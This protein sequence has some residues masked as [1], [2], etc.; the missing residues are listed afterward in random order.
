MKVQVD[1]AEA[2]ATLRPGAATAELSSDDCVTLLV[3][4]EDRTLALK[5]APLAV[6]VSAASVR[7][8]AQRIILNLT[9][10]DAAE[11]AETLLKAKV[12]ASDD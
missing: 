3:D 2:A 10:A 9:K 5:L 1:Y 11:E 6:K 4:T 8:L 12:A 7:I